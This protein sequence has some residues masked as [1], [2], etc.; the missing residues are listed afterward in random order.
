MIR[1]ALNTAKCE[2]TNHTAAVLQFGRELRITDDVTHD[3]RAL[4]DNDSFVAEITPYLKRFARLTA[5]IKDHIEQKQDKRIMYYDLRRRQS[6]YKPGDQEWVTLHPISKSQNKKSR[7]FMP[8]REVPYLVITN[9]SPTTYDIADSAKPY[10]VLGSY[11]TSALRAY[12][13]PVSR[14][15]GTKEI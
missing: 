14:N 9:R 10:E 15:N 4:I 11:H 3:L 8:K 6:F 12:E 7:K 13:L 1:F 2:T 5:E